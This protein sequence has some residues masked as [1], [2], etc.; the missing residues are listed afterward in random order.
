MGVQTVDEVEVP[1]EVLQ[2]YGLTS[3][4]KNRAIALGLEIESALIGH[5]SFATVLVVADR[6][7]DDYLGRI[8]EGKNIKLTDF[9]SVEMYLYDE[10]ILSKFVRMMTATPD[11]S[12]EDLMA[13]LTIIGSDVF[14]VR[15]ANEMLGWGMKIADPTRV[16]SIEDDGI[17]RLNLDEL[18]NRTVRLNAR[19]GDFDEFMETVQVCRSEQPDEPRSKIRGHDFIDILHCSLRSD[20]R[21]R[22]AGRSADL[23]L[24]HLLMA[25]D[26][27][28]LSEYD[29]FIRI[30]DVFS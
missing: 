7:Y 27:S 11:R 20:I 23:V 4:N 21:P 12:L 2:K 5:E 19:Y 8:L 15:T 30:D 1:I 10:Q 24:S 17:A 6:D 3:S 18:V 29:L 14:A 28:K 16:I 22:N 25:A 9:T 26:A 13:S